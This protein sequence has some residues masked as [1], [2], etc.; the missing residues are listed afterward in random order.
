[1][2]TFVFQGLFVVFEHFFILVRCYAIQ[3]LLIVLIES[4]CAIVADVLEGC[5]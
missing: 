2:V 1:M 5:V 3:T 4:H